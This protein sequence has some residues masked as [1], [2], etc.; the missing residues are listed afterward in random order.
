[1]KTTI[2]LLSI[3]FLFGILFIACDKKEDPIIDDE[4]DVLV[5]MQGEW[6]SSGT[7]VAPLLSTYFAV[8]SI[9]AK[10][11]TDN[12]YLV[13]SFDAQGVK[14]TYS[15]TYVQTE[16]TGSTI[17]TILLNQSLPSSGT[18]EGIFELYTNQDSYDMQYEVVQTQPD[19]NAT[20]PT[21]TAGFG[22]SNGGALGTLNIQKYFR[23]EK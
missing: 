21:A 15:G 3:A 19:I 13:E 8:D 23:I 6:Y 20:P 22:S 14:T 16:N 10:F 17:W 12:T 7:N 9:Y 4:E 11:N 2:K 1:M 18:S 5:G